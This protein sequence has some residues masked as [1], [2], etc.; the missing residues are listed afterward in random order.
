MENEIKVG[1]Y[2]K[3]KNGKIIKFV[4]FGE[5]HIHSKSTKGAYINEK[6]HLVVKTIATGDNRHFKYDNIVKHSPNLIDLIQCGDYV[7]GYK[8]TNVINKEP[9]PSGKC[10]DIDADRP[11]EYCTLWEDNIETVVTKEQFESISY[12]VERK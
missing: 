6:G 3:L 10:V 12:K 7:N 8:V 9:C 5:L 1:E 11:S 2:V 4:K